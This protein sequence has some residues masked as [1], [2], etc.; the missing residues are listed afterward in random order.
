MDT[1]RIMHTSNNPY[2]VELATAAE[3]TRDKFNAVI[4]HGMSRGQSLFT[5]LE[6]N[7]P[8][9]R[10][11]ST[12]GMEFIFDA[13]KG[14]MVNPGE[15]D[16][17][18]M[19]R[20]AVRQLATRTNI[21]TV[22]NFDKL[23]GAGQWGQELLIEILAKSFANVERE[24]LL[25][26]AVQGEARAFLTDSFMR[27]DSTAVLA[28]LLEA[29]HTYGA[30][31]VE[32]RFT[33]TWWSMSLVLKKIYEPTKDDPVLYGLQIKNS[34]FGCGALS[35][36]GFFE[37]LMCTNKM[38]K[39]AHFRRTHLGPRLP[40][41]LQM[42]MDT[43]E[44]QQELMTKITRDGINHL[45]CESTVSEE[46]DLIKRSNETDINLKGTVDGLARSGRINKSEK[47]DLL[48]TYNT[49]ESPELLPTST[50]KH[51]LWRLSNAM[52]LF[53]QSPDHTKDRS[54]ELERF[55]GELIERTPSTE[56]QA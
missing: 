39:K 55:A 29:I 46:L 33:D 34:D 3:Y 24:R 35:V 2:E 1:Q 27:I 37:R 26:R 14:L 52:S 22:A 40:E 7:A 31:P 9:D 6:Q 41:N 53:A 10:M 48:D 4:E 49:P 19:H 25:M 45:L 44:T 13:E 30:V 18:P 20:N 56:L 54:M 16:D 51:S 42:A 28:H 8:A 47:Q 12:R 17:I 23:M 38:T 43:L 5:H 15:G 21:F 32:A 11:I 36:G 50:G